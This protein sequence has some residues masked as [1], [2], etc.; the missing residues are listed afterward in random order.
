MKPD[1]SWVTRASASLAVVAASV[2]VLLIPGASTASTAADP[3]GCPAADPISIA[4]A[5]CEST[6][7]VVP[8][9]D[10]QWSEDFVP[11]PESKVRTSAPAAC[12]SVSAVFY[13]ETDWLRLAQKMRAN[14]S[15]CAD[16]YVSIPPLAADKTKLRNGEAAKIRALGPQMHA[17]AEANV[18]GW[19]SWVNAGNGTWYDAGVEMRNRMIAAGFDVGAGDIWGLNELSSAVRT[20]TGNARANMRDFIRGL[21]TAGGNGPLVKGVVWTI[22]IGQPTANLTTYRRNLEGWLQDPAFWND[23][24][25]YVAYWSQEVFGD[26]RNW[27][28][29]GTDNATRR[30]RLVEYLEQVSV[31][32]QAAPAENADMT[33]TLEAADAP[34]A[35]AAWAWTSGFGYTLS[36]VTQMEAY[37]SSQVYALRNYQSRAPWLS[38]DAFGF[39]WSPQNLAALG[40]TPSQFTI[41]T[42]AL[43]DRLAAAIHDTDVPTDDPGSAACGSDGSLCA[44]DIAGASFNLGWQIFGTWV[45]SVLD[46][47]ETTAEDTPVAIPLV[48]TGGGGT[49]TFTIVTPPQHGTLT[50]DTTGALETYTPAP[51]YNGT[52]LF[53]FKAF[54]GLVTSRVATM[55][56]A[57]TPVN[58]A[59]TVTLDQPLPVGE[60]SPVTLTAHGA[61]VDGDALT[62]TWTT[63]VGTLTPSGPTTTLVADGGPATAHVTVTADDGN[64]GTATASVDVVVENVPPTVDAGPNLAATWGIPLSI[65]GAAT[66]PSAADTAAGLQASWDFGDASPAAAGFAVSH[67]YANPGTYT[68]TLTATDK[69]GGIGTGTATVTVGPRPATVEYA[70]PAGLEASSA[71]VAARLVDA[72]DGTTARLAGHA[73]TITVGAG[74]CEGTTDATGVAR[75]VIDASSAPLGP[76]TATV[77]FAGDDLYAAAGAVTA[78]V[79]LYALPTGG[80]FVVGDLAVAHDVVFW[81]PLWWL[82]NPTSSGWA[83]PTFFGFASTTAPA[84]GANWTASPLFDHV[85]KK[86]P[87]WTA[88]IVA[89]K[90]TKSGSTIHGDAARIVVVHTRG[91]NPLLGGWGTVVATVC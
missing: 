36:P 29:P 82:V 87:A 9:L 38:G 86:V 76:A 7:P 14:P 45:P 84:C 48:A 4:A 59:P 78:P 22:G 40:L 51:D 50:A 80:T 88:V 16:Y 70:G 56:I 91:F 20:A 72:L 46:S 79:V 44:T 15:A 47:T 63:D 89:S 1:R 69:D 17:V 10:P 30:D 34:L 32:S 6:T 24:N 57:I 90:V 85:A 2:A 53:T 42:A 83:P 12:R 66:D 5:E 60:G 3:A 28:V 21:A 55:Q 52:D 58:D 25:Q 27:A 43:L 49:L 13:T 75:C 61:D 65:A 73:V 62:Y 74:T 68:A 11:P 19:T 31:L 37:V 67:A 8:S 64:G 35:N 81:S 18:T 23:V 39:A 26:V 33:A 77:S 54:D 41:Q 71:H